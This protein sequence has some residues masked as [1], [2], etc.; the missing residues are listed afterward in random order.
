VLFRSRVVLA[1]EMFQNPLMLEKTT[2]WLRQI[3][4]EVFSSVDLPAG[5]KGLALGRLAVAAKMR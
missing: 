3:G 4:F 1:G 2:A 5:Y